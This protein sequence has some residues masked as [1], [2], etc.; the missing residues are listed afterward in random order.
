MPETVA[1]RTPKP[2]VVLDDLA[3]QLTQEARS[4]GSGHAAITLNPKAQ[5]FKQTLVSLA[6][7]TA[8][9]PDHWNGPASILVLD[10]AVRMSSTG[11]TVESGCWA[12]LPDDHSD[13]VAERDTTALLSVAPSH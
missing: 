2:P 6:A 5:G 3:E 13:V 7:D 9:D 1:D 8:L 10:G 12:P 11:M 4:A